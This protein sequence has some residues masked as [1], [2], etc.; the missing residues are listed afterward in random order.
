MKS[1]GGGG[2]GATYMIS[3]SLGGSGD[4]PQKLFGIFVL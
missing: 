2:G 1:G 4:L 3:Y